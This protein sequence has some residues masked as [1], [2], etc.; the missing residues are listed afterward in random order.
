MI[1][2][3]KERSEAK[4][5]SDNESSTRYCE[6]LLPVSEYN[7]LT[8]NDMTIKTGRMENI[9]GIQVRDLWDLEVIRGMLTEGRSLRVFQ[10]VVS[11]YYTRPLRQVS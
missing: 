3:G 2:S 4:Q 7:F 1:F 5:S 9:S 6:R 8:Q 10:D 11:Y